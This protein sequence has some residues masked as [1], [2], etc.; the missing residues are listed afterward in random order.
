MAGKKGASARP[1]SADQTH[2]QPKTSGPVEKPQASIAESEFCVEIEEV[3]DSTA[4][5]SPTKKVQ[6][7]QVATYAQ[8]MV[9][10][11]L[12]KSAACR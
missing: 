3:D 1:R 12:R 6:Q 2:R 11:R 10:H 8:L 5:S 7:G 4:V 9:S